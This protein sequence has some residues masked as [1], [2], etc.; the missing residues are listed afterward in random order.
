M[1]I[2]EMRNVFV[3]CLGSLALLAGCGGFTEDVN[4]NI[5]DGTPVDVNQMESVYAL[6]RVAQSGKVERSSAGDSITIVFEINGG[7]VKDGESLAYDPNFFFADSQT[8]AYSFRGDTLLLSTIY[9]PGPYEV[10]QERYEESFI[11]VGGTP[12]VLDGIWKNTQCRYREEKIYCMNDGYDQYFKFDGG[13]VEIRV[14]DREDYDYMQTVFVDQL[15]DF[16]GSGG[17]IQLET[18]YYYSD[19]K[20]EQEEYGI[21]ILEKT[22]TAMKFTYGDL[23][24]DLSLDYAYYKDSL[25]VTLKSGDVTCVGKHREIVNVPPE[26]CNADYVD[27]FYEI[28][29]TGL[30]KYEKKND[31][32]FEA[33]IDGI[34]GR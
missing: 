32:E 29:D 33:C 12:G 3:F 25:S 6:A 7:C 17:S 1:K 30:L 14:A 11:F 10:N 34:L 5:V 16:L 19:T 28:E 18:P 4:G 2:S 20:Y 23:T 22:N 9:E 27:N 31:S 26:M 8:F 13:K 24:F 21:G 15:F